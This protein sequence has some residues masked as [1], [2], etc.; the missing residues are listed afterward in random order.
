MDSQNYCYY[1][2]GKLSA[3]MSTFNEMLFASR[4]SNI[5]GDER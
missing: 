4:M 2:N 5:D 1:S 3:D